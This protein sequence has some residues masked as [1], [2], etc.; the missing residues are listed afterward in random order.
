MGNVAI[1]SCWFGY[2]FN[3]PLKITSIATFKRWLYA[4][5]KNRLP[6]KVL[7]AFGYDSIIPESPHSIENCFF[8]SNN[9]KLR[10]EALYKGWHFCF[11]KSPIHNGESI[12]S[13]L[14]AKKVKFLQVEDCYSDKFY[15]VDHLIYMDSRR[16]SDD[17][18]NIIQTNE[19]GILI[20]YESRFKPTVWH[21]VEEAKGQERYS[22]HMDA[23]IDFINCKLEEGYL[24]DNRVMNTGIIAYSMQSK[25]VK[26][27]IR[28]LCNEVYNA[29]SELN[30]P[31]C[32]IFW[33][34]LS[35]RYTDIL[36]AVEPS[37][38][39]SRQGL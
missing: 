18:A 29:C 35:Q 6:F 16:I 19:K 38:I 17:I 23:T 27:K 4:T 15:N 1:L 5:V 7:D 36:K 30:Q 32:Q 2:K 8:Y 3:K 31:E 28:A 39:K 10:A 9:I 24:A 25:E 12:A 11:I 33:C 22:K 21:E 20:R 34:V 14:L 13:S 26:I 37:G